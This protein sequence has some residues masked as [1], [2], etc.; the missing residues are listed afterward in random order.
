MLTLLLAHTVA[1]SRHH[2]FMSPEGNPAWALSR[3]TD[4]QTLC[5]KEVYEVADPAE[6][7]EEVNCT[8]C[9]KRISGNVG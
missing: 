9:L 8:E 3:Y 2:A 4:A 6:V 7:E 1:D 5:G